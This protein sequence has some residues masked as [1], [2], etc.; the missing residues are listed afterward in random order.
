MSYDI[1]IT[2]YGIA[3]FDGEKLFEKEFKGVK[4]IGGVTT[5]GGY[6]LTEKGELYNISFNGKIEKNI[7]LKDTK[8]NGIKIIQID[9]NDDFIVALDLLGDI[10]TYDVKKREWKK[11]D[12]FVNKF[13][14]SKDNILFIKDETS[15][16]Y[17]LKTNQNKV[18]NR[19]IL[20]AYSE[21]GKFFIVSDENKKTALLEVNFE[22]ER[23]I[24]GKGEYRGVLKESDDFYYYDGKIFVLNEKT[25][26]Q[27]YDMKSKEWVELKM[28]LESKTKRVRESKNG[29]FILTE[30]GTLIKYID[31]NISI[32]NDIQSFEI[33]DEKL[34]TLN[35]NGILS[36]DNEEKKFKKSSSFSFETILG[37][38]KT[39]KIYVVFKNGIEQYNLEDGNWE[40]KVDFS[41]EVKEYSYFDEKIYCNDGKKLEVLK[42]TDKV[43]NIHEFKGNI[44]SAK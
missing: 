17:N 7:V 11:I 28:F 20:E 37:V 14:I 35:K 41:L 38:I 30:F 12:S 19:K 18:M 26:L 31:G 29:L 25:A 22:N 21:N 16:L 13:L 8:Y 34:Y 44:L 39:D 6:L 4:D 24:V 42:L 10:Y 15:T 33:K 23:Y 36:I 1:Y 5:S 32:E 3:Y 9:M 27:Y 2:D 40:N 43:S